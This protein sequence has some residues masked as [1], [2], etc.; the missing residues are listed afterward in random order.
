MTENKQTRLGHDEIF[1]AITYAGVRP[2]AR[3]AVY[4][5]MR[6]CH[7]TDGLERSLSE[8]AANQ[9]TWFYGPT[10]MPR[11]AP[12]PYAPDAERVRA[13]RIRV[14][15]VTRASIEK[16]LKEKEQDREWLT[17]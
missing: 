6:H 9:P 1:R 8:L 2:S 10:H 4:S 15:N 7:D 5:M 14:C 3:P 13:E 11:P 17:P 16:S 12:Q